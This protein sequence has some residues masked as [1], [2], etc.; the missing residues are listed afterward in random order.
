MRLPHAAGMARDLGQFDDPPREVE[1]W[2]G[3]YVKCSAQVPL[4]HHYDRALSR[5][6]GATRPSDRQTPATRER[7]M[8]S[9][10]NG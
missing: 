3:S 1:L 7:A 6:P 5:Q 4:T 9:T 8:R 2:P 10:E